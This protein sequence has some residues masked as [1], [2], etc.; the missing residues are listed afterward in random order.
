MYS[1]AQQDHYPSSA[2]SPAQKRQRSSGEYENSHMYQHMPVGEAPMPHYSGAIPSGTR[3]DQQRM[4]SGGYAPQSHSPMSMPMM[5]R[6]Q[7]SISVQGSAGWQNM[8]QQQSALPSP[9]SSGSNQQPSYPAVAGQQQQPSL[10]GDPG[11][12]ASAIPRQYYNNSYQYQS[13]GQYQ[14]QSSGEAQS[15]Y[16]DLQMPGS[17]IP[18]SGGLASAQ[19][20]SYNSGYMQSNGIY[21][22]EAGEAPA[23]YPYM[24]EGHHK[25]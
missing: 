25:F 14:N 5:N 10:F 1:Q 3:Y 12:A 21:A 19:N 8:N 2:Q 24:G 22:S 16:P 7:Q 6:A 11:S 20:Q 9:S 23:P 18:D 15:A 13:Q 4:H 17:S